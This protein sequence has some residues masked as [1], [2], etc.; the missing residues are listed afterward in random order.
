MFKTFKIFAMVIVI[1]K[2]ATTEDIKEAILKLGKNIFNKK[3][4]H[5]KEIIDA[6]FG[7]DI[8]SGNKTPLE[9]QKEMRDDWN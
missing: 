7:K 1:K 5:K 6:T 8:F 9:I 4:I 2:N 3:S